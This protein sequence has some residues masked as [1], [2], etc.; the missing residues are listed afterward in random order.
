MIDAKKARKI[1]DDYPKIQEKRDRKKI[2]E[3][4][5]GSASRGGSQILV[6]KNLVSTTIYDELIS[7]GYKIKYYNLTE[8]CEISWKEPV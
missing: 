8:S 3:G 6:P 7:Q 4:I 5:E 2:Y 1:R